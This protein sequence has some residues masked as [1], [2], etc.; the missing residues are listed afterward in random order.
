MFILN[1]NASGFKKFDFK[2]G[3]ENYLKD[4]NLDFDYEIKCSTKEGESILI[5]ENAVKDGFNELIAVGGDGTINEVGNVAIKNNLKLGVIPA[6]TGN[7]YMNSLNESCNFVICMERIIRGSTILVDYGSFLDKSFFNIASVGFD[8]EV[9]EYAVKVKKIIKSGFAYKI[10]I[11]LAL[12]HHKRKR[13]KLIIDDVEYEDDYFL[14]AIGIGS[15]YGGKINILPYADMQDGLLDI[16]AI[17][18]KSKFDIIKKIKTIVNATHVNEDITSCFKAKKIKVIS[19][20]VEINFDGEYMSGVDDV[21]FI[22]NDKK[23][24]LIM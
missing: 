11:A 7:D 19:K 2:E 3:I 15:K 24:E 22:V 5:A 10:A 23:V 21:E 14:I 8:A 17:R 20:N 16:C 13:Y 18:Y 1:P 6:G 9:N 4:K 12:F